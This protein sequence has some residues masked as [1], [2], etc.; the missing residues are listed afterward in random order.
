FFLSTKF[1]LKK[2]FNILH[3]VPPLGQWIKEKSYAQ[4]QKKQTWIPHREP[5]RPPRPYTGYLSN[6]ISARFP[7]NSTKAN[8]MAAG[9][10]NGA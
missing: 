5:G 6:S 1:F 10:R 8:L 4:G 9:I 3:P 7:R 2:V